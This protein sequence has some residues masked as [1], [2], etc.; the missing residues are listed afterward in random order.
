MPILASFVG[1]RSQWTTYAGRSF[2]WISAPPG[3][4]VFVLLR[5][6]GF[7][8]AF[9]PLVSFSAQLTPPAIRLV[10][11]TRPRSPDESIFYQSI[12]ISSFTWKGMPLT[13]NE[14]KHPERSCARCGTS[15][16]RASRPN[17]R[18]LSPSHSFLLISF[19]LRTLPLSYK[20]S[21]CIPDAVTWRPVMPRLQQTARA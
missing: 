16:P 9:Q 2:S 21:L 5:L 19:F 11:G 15:L 4:L 14:E 12:L 17:Y 20:Y 8:F 1:E 3:S 18:A 6:S 13:W 7:F 10:R